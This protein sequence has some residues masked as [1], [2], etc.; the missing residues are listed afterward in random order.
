MAD[1]DLHAVVRGYNSSSRA[2]G[3]AT[4]TTTTSLL[5]DFW[6]QSWLCCQQ[7]GNGHLVSQPDPFKARVA[8]TTQELHELF[9]PFFPQ[10]QSP[11]SPQSISSTPLS[12]LSSLSPSTDHQP[13]IQRPLEPQKPKQSQAATCTASTPKSIIGNTHTSSRSKRR[14]NQLKKVCQVPVEAL[15]SDI[16][17]WRKYGQKPI[18]GSPYPRGYYRCS[19]SK[20]CLARKQVERDRSDPVMFIV[21]YTGDHN[22]PAPTHRNSLAGSTRRK[23]FTPQTV[24]ASDSSKPHSPATSVEEEEEETVPQSRNKKNREED[25]EMINEDDEEVEFRMTGIAVSDDFFDGLEGLADG[26]CFPDHFP[27]SF[28]F[29]WFASSAATAAGSVF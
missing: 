3:T 14:K 21:T 11:L 6:S 8:N 18:K 20:G 27:A 2:T 10:N 7:N 1:W 5:P 13:Q 26:D 25:K 29:P 15:S 22:H 19:S 28:G 16:W 23:P 24:T 4:T 9:K 12:P 17:A